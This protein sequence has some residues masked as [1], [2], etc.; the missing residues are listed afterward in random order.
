MIN[1]VMLGLVDGAPIILAAIG[2]TL[3]YS[4]NGF[5]NVAYAENLTLGAYFAVVF[6]ST[7]GLNFFVA[8]IP[9]AILAG[10]V[11]VLSYLLV[12][13]P[14]MRRGVGPT[15]MIVLSVGLSFLIR[16]ALRLPFGVQLYTFEFTDTSYIRVLG[17]GVTGAQ[18]IS[19][20]LVVA[21]SM[22]LYWFIYKTTLGQRMRALASN[23][24]L[25]L[26]SGI[27]PFRVSVIVWFFAGVAGGLAGMFLGVFAFVDYLLGWNTILIIIMV[28]IL[29]GVGNLK[30]AVAAGFAASVFTALVTRYSSPAYAQVALL[31]LFI[32]VLKARAMRAGG[33]LLKLAR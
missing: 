2:F 15:E 8:I 16:H 24:D 19:L 9:A 28:V 23:P 32:V 6:N 21:I 4:F 26:A 18:L 25:A 1:S 20:L 11:S 22:A 12:F 31:V 10:L 17:T 14:A 3:I 30:G 7:L 33:P 13:R 29:G 27:N 5:I